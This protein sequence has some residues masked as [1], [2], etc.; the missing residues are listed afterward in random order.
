MQKTVNK[1]GKLKFQVRAFT[2]VE[3]LASALVRDR[4][5]QDVGQL[6]TFAAG[7]SNCQAFFDLVDVGAGKERADRKIRGRAF[8]FLPLYPSCHSDP[9][10]PAD[11][12]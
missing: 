4:R 2:N 12:S 6:R 9:G 1:F 5:L 3:G 10:T 11:S 8:P 7:C